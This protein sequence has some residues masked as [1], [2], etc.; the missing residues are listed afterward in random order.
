[1]KILLTKIRTLFFDPIKKWNV[2]SKDEGARS[3]SPLK[4]N[5][6][7]LDYPRIELSENHVLGLSAWM[8]KILELTSI[9]DGA[10]DILI[11]D[12]WP[13]EGRSRLIGHV[14]MSN[15][16][17]GHDTGFRVCANL[18][19]S[20]IEG[21]TGDDIPLVNE[22]LKQAVLTKSTQRKLQA[23]SKIHDFDLCLTCWGA[24]E[25]IK[26]KF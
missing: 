25:G 14:Q 13:N 3:L 8:E 7:E 17:F 18:K 11:A 6:S 26:I 22:W 1:M 10:W 21:D 15:V 16:P 5:E 23:L 9:H 4:W 12:L 19:N 20:G 2:A 24:D